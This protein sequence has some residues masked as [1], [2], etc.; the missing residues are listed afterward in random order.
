[1]K[2]I[3]VILLLL[4][5]C[6]NWFGYRLLISFMEEKADIRMEAQLN[7]NNYDHSQLVSVKVP[8]SH[9]S[10]Y[11]HSRPFERM[12]G[13]IEIAGTTYNYVKI[14]LYNDSIEMLYI[15]N[16]NVTNLQAAKGDLFKIVNDLQH[17]GNKKTGAD[18]SKNISSDYIA[19]NCF[20]NCTGGC[21]ST[22]KWPPHFTGPL[23]SYCTSPIENPPE[24]KS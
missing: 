13:Q 8:A 1:M 10:G 14:K 16:Q 15:P 11:V 24:S 23:R 18:L 3:A 22:Q 17:G 12:D 6:F 4:F 20:Y 19:I 21:F 7:E 2:K 5:L 9:F